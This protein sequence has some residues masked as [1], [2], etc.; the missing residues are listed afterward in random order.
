MNTQRSGFKRVAIFLAGI[1]TASI[2]VMAHA[3]WSIKG[4]G[5]LAGIGVSSS[6]GINDSGQV[7]GISHTAAGG[8]YQA[9]FITGANGTGMAELG[10]LGADS[11]PSGINDSGQIAGSFTIAGGAI[12]HAFT[13]GAN[14]VGITDLGTLGGSFSIASGIN[15]SGQIVGGSYTAGDGPTHAFITDAG[16]AGMSDLGTLGGIY[17]FANGINDSGHVVG[18]SVTAGSDVHAFF[19]GANGVGM[20]DLGTLGGAFS[21]AASINDSGRVVGYSETANGNLHAFITDANGTG[22]TELRVGGNSIAIDINDL[23]QVLGYSGND[24]FLVG[25]NGGKIDLSL[26]DVVVAEGWTDIQVTGINNH[27]QIAGYGHHHNFGTEAFLLS[28]SQDTIFPPPIPEPE[29]YVMLLAGLSLIGFMVRRRR[30]SD[31]VKTRWS[32]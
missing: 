16:G 8:S 11:Y 14:G 4:L 12:T 15:N 19:T 10:T 7:T 25:A 9:L 2:S 26:L 6:Y 20:T 30:N 31:A 21:S 28:F 5:T 32:S 22:M 29:T 1:S 17:S 27:G 24:P 13:T 18:E 3:D 23:N